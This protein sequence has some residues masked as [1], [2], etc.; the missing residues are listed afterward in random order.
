MSGSTFSPSDRLRPPNVAGL[1]SLT[2]SFLFVRRKRGPQTCAPRAAPSCRERVRFGFATLSYWTDAFCKLLLRFC[3]LEP[4]LC[5]F[6]AAWASLPPALWF[7]ISVLTVD[8]LKTDEWV[9]QIP[10]LVS[11]VTKRAA[12]HLWPSCLGGERE[13]EEK[14]RGF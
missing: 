1:W 6:S 14:E 13:G 2:G 9:R 10:P 11:S 5:S 4:L 3:I 8:Y 7:G 12:S